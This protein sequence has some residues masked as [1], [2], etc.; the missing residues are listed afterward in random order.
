M[1]ISRKIYLVS[2]SYSVF[3]LMVAIVTLVVDDGYS[4]VLI[5]QGYVQV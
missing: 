5:V 2:D 1:N 3:V 4:D